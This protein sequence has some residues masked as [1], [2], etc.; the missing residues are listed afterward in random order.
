MAVLIL[1]SRFTQQPQY[2]TRIDSGNPICSDLVSAWTN[3][4]IGFA[5]GVRP[6]T[7]GTVSYGA[8][9]IGR[10]FNGTSD[11]ISLPA[12][13]ITPAMGVSSGVFTRFAV[14]KVGAANSTRSISG[15]GNGT[16]G[17]RLTNG[18]V[19]VLNV[20]NTVLGTVSGVVSANEI[21]TLGVTVGTGSGAGDPMSVYKNGVL[22][23]STTLSNGAPTVVGAPF[24]GSNGASAQY[25]DGTI[26]AHLHFSRVKSAAE[27]LALHNNMWQVFQAPRRKLF[28]GVTAGIAL[29]ATANSG[30]QAAQS[31]YTFNR[32]V[33]GSN[34]FLAV[35][36]HILSV[37]GTT[38][39]SVVDDSAGAAV[40]MTLIG[41]KSTVSGAGR[42]ECWGLAGAATGTKTIAV[43]LTASVASAATAV[44]YTGAHQTSPT[45]G[46]SSAQATNVGAAFATV[47]IT[48]VADNCWIHGACVS[49]DTTIT[50]NQTSRNNVTG[51]LGS[52]ANEDNNG[53]KTP[54]GV[55]TMSYDVSA[56]GTW[57]IGG[58]AIRPIAASSL[59]GIIANVVYGAFNAVKG[60][61]S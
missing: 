59:G 38:V 46:F 12:G 60:Y 1:P 29:D 21:C 49:D 25:F 50:A 20:G 2:P 19:V 10:A 30:Y 4:S 61:F 13:S 26:W 57:A 32:T 15:S 27:I 11:T 54:A 3:N 24:I 17:W 51:A 28:F 42:I 55:V 39:T 45:E 35:D 40:A 41:V 5:G 44:S 23:G 36:V 9:G 47:D 14:V 48:S 7:G 18:D 34:T 33:T 31:T 53:P 56:L 16:L 37:P 8:A 58:Y 22:F 6:T 52:G 43:T